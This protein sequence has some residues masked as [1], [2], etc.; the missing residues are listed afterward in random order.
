[1]NGLGVRA[2]K[3]G[4]VL[5]G[6]SARWLR[7][8]F[9]AVVR[10]ANACTCIGLA[11]RQDALWTGPLSGGLWA[12]A[13]EAPLIGLTARGAP[14]DG[15]APPIG[16]T[17]RGAPLDWEG[18]PIGVTARGAPL[19][20]EGPLIGVTAR[21]A[22]PDS[23]APPKGVT[24]RGAPLDWEAPPIGLVA[25]APPLGTAPLCAW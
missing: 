21:G 7:E 3:P 11:V 6:D 19:D 17:A 22:P 4:D 16:L 13:W 25:R 1:M 8:A 23:E 12:A 9:I 18:P 15:D 14:L 2:V 20:R 10:E 5:L 24:A